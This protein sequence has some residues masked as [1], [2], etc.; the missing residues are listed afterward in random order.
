VSSE[1]VTRLITLFNVLLDSPR[2]IPAHE[3]RIRVPGY[4]DNDIAFRRAF[5]RDKAELG[6]I[7]GHPIRAEKIPATDPPLDGYRIRAQDAYLRDPGLT[8][9]ERRAVAVAAS[10]IRLA[11]IDP[12]RAAD[13]IGA[14]GPEPEEATAVGAELPVDARV[15]ALFRAVSERRTATFDYRGEERTVEPRRLRFAKGRWYLEAHDVGRGAQ[16][17]FRLDRMSA[18]TDLGAPD[19]FAPA[20]ASPAGPLDQPWSLGDGPYHDVRVLVDADRAEAAV[21]SAAGAD[22]E[23]RDDGSVVLTLAVRNRDALRSFVL[24]FLDG[25]EIL[26]PPDARDDMRAWLVPIAA[27]SSTEPS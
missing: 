6:E 2:L 13:K 24:G 27:S 7:L 22:V 12:S 9:D 1:K 26:D 18:L 16:R 25:A 5:E 20:P 19:G 21:R 8:P 17:M 11:G 15:V 10:A 14:G 4:S 23:T 3:I